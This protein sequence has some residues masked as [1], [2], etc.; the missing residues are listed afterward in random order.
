MRVLEA[1]QLGQ[2]QREDA[3]VAKLQERI[4]KDIAKQPRQMLGQIFAV[5]FATACERLDSLGKEVHPLFRRNRLRHQ[6]P[7]AI[8]RQSADEEAPLATQLHGFLIE[9]IHE[10]VDQR[11]RDEFHLIRRQR[12]LA[13]Q[14]I[15]TSVDAVLGFRSELVSEVSM[16]PTLPNHVSRNEPLW[17]MP[18]GD[19]LKD[20]REWSGRV[21]RSFESH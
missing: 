17:R 16:S 10:L 3:A 12:Q 18:S 20:C 14:Y 4:P 21:L 11:Q 7:P 8:L 15:A 9:V 6:R 1:I 19:S 13:D 5:R 2:K